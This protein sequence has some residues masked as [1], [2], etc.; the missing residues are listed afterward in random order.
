MITGDGGRIREDPST[1]TDTDNTTFEKKGGEKM[2]SKGL[3]LTQKRGEK[4]M[5]IITMVIVLLVSIAFAGTALAVPSG[6]TLEFPSTM[7]KVVFDGK[8][9]ADK[10]FK[11]GDCHTKIFP[12]KQTTITMAEINAGME[13]GVCHNGEKAFKASDPANCTKCHKK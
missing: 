8:I 10:G 6:K 9:H 4:K 5:K 7:G 1:L 3:L 12:M 11:C 13:C 2:R